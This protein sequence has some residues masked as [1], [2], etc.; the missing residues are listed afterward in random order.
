M[1]TYTIEEFKQG[2]KAVWIENQGQWD[3]VNKKCMLAGFICAGW[4]SNSGSRDT[5]EVNRLESEYHDIGFDCFDFSQLVFK[6]EFV[7][8]KLWEISITPENAVLIVTL[9]NSRQNTKIWNIKEILNWQL[10]YFD[11]EEHYVTSSKSNGSLMLTDSQFK[12]YVLKQPK[13]GKEIIGYR[14]IKKEYKTAALAIIPDS[15]YLKTGIASSGEPCLP[16]AVKD[17]STYSLLKKAGVLD[18]WFEPVYK[19]DKNLPVINGKEGSY[20]KKDIVV[21]YGNDCAKLSVPMLDLVHR[22]NSHDD[23]NRS[24]KSITLD[25]GVS[26]TMG[27][28]GE[29]LDYVK[30]VNEQ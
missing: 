19:D 25:S 8:P 10:M 16:M 28:I 18:L 6:E 5:I 21:V 3:R 20:K 22:S 29:I 23:G 14:L 11:G 17:T 24:I 9:F 7:L 4:Y 12:Q 27:Q 1:K 2:K 13:M 15:E 26:I 30:F